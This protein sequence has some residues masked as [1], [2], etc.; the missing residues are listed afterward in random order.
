MAD[1]FRTHR[2]VLALGIRFL[3]SLFIPF[4]VGPGCLGHPLWWPGR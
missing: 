4:L 1:T 2:L 3:G